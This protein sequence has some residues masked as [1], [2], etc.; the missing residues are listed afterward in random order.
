MNFQIEGGTATDLEGKQHKV[1]VLTIAAEEGRAGSTFFLEPEE[2]K[3][4]GQGLVEGARATES[5][6]IAVGADAM[7]KGHPG[8]PPMPGMPGNGTPS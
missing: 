4:I 1:L 3:R 8:V 5:G 6:I 2:A 7:P